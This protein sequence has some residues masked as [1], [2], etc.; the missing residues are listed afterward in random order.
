M[1][2]PWWVEAMGLAAGTCTTLSLFPQAARIWRTKSAGDLSLAM[3]S[4]FGCGLILW[5][6]YGIVTHSLSVI[7]ANAVSLAAVLVILALAVRYRSKPDPSTEG[8][9]E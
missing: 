5:L 1:A 8:P 9:V 3:F 4:I 6:G 2:N 7:L